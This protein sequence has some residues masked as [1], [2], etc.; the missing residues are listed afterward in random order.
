MRIPGIFEIADFDFVPWGNAYFN[1]TSGDTTYCQEKNDPPACN[2]KNGRNDWLDKCG[3][4]ARQPVP[5]ACWEGTSL[6]QHGPNECLANLIE[7]CAVAQYPSPTADGYPEY[8]DFVACYE[9]IT[10]GRDPSRNAS[11]PV[12]NMYECMRQL[13]YSEEGARKL[14]ECATSD[15]ITAD[16]LEQAAAMRT[17]RSAKGFSG[18][19]Y[20]AV[21]GHATDA[22]KVLAEVCSRYRGAKQV[23]ACSNLTAR[24]Q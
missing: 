9:G 5:A 6:C 2:S 21:D 19:P 13:D 18:T 24:S 10:I 14:E 4:A 17:A 15:A 20:I 11:V 1:G 8:W 23:A 7:N 16:L 22:D 3:A 12:D